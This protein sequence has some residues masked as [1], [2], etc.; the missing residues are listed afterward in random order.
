MSSFEIIPEDLL[1]LAT[2]A[3]REMYERALWRHVALMTPM[4]FALASRPETRDFKAARYVSD[5]IAGLHSGERLII[6]EPPRH[7]K[8]FVVSETVPAWIHANDPDAGIIHVTYSADFTAKKFGS[9]NRDL[10][11]RSSELGLG[12]RVSSSSRSNDFYSIHK[13][14]GL[15]FYLATGPGGRITGEGGNW[16]IVDDL[17]KNEEEARSKHIRDKTWDFFVGD[18]LSRLEPG[19]NLILM[20]TPRHE[21]DVLHRAMAL[22]GYNI[23]HLPAIAEED[24]ELGREP[25]QALVPERFDEA[26]LAEIRAADERRW[27]TQYQL[28]PRPQDGEIFKAE[29]FREWK[30]LPE[31][32]YYFATVDLAHSVKTRADYSVVSVWFASAP[33]NPR[34][35][36]VHVFRDKV[37]SGDHLTWIDA[38][39]NSLDKDERPRWAGVE[40]KTFGSTLLSA[41]RTANRRGKVLFRPLKADN[42]K[43]TRA[44][45]AVALGAQGQLYIPA[46]DTPWKEDWIAEHLGFDRSAHDDQVDCTAYAALEFMRGRQADKAPSPLP[47]QTQTEKAWSN[48]KKQKR[49][50]RQQRGRKARIGV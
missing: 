46:E 24:D 39:F 23:V 2:P 35:H 14:D 5:V 27:T 44:Q 15:G 43:I 33:P 3:E 41:A 12:P 20:M 13:E 18:C 30:K 48:I 7:G 31:K 26:A 10:A 25:G 45:T 28:R 37:P 32:G 22:G 11:V 4:D 49:L 38:C 17:I 16:I 34:L 47:A 9:K 29:H 6:K 21:D 36:L 1:A 42:D 50:K 40:D 19:G 8:S